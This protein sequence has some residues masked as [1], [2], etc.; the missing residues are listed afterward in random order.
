M[1]NLSTTVKKEVISW[2]KTILLAAVLAGLV[3][4]FLIVNAEVPTGSM[5]NTIMA[6]DRILALRTSYWF[7]EPEAG[8]DLWSFNNLIKVFEQ[9]HEKTSGSIIIISH[10]ERILNIADRIIVI[11]DGQVRKSGSREEVLEELLAA[12]TGCK[13]YKGQ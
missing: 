1:G 2:V 5:E 12:D 7:D 9:M 3:N 10:Q 4:S 8:I 13:Y 11:A 6:G